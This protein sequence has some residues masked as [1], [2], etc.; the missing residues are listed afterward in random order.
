MHFSYWVYLSGFYCC[1]S[2]LILQLFTS[3]KFVMFNAINI[4]YIYKPSLN[5]FFSYFTSMR[6]LHRQITLKLNIS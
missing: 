2:N 3:N 1:S 6:N 5:P 4:I